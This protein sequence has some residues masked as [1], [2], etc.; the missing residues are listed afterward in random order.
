VTVIER[1]WLCT[2]PRIY[3]IKY[4]D[5]VGQE[6]R[7]Y[8]LRGEGKKLKQGEVIS[9]KMINNKAHLAEEK[10]NRKIVLSFLC[11]LYFVLFLGLWAYGFWSYKVLAFI[12]ATFALFVLIF[13]FLYKRQMSKG[14][15]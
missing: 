15:D 6:G 14:L 12:V 9:I 1:T 13:A 3:I 7:L 11:G 10:Y 2:A 8:A 5:E 4:V